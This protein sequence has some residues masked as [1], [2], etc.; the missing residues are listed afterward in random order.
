MV[1]FRSALEPRTVAERLALLPAA[2]RSRF[3]ARM[4]DDQLIDFLHD[5]RV[6]ARPEQLPPEGDW[7]IWGVMSGRGAGKTRLAGEWFREQIESGD[8]PHS[9][10]V[11]R[12]AGDVRKTMIEGPSGLL[13]ICHPDFYP[14]YEPSKKQIT[15]P[16]GSI[17]LLFN[18]TEP[19]EAR[20][21]QCSLF[22][23]DEVAAWKRASEMWDQ[24][25]MGFRLGAHPRGVFTTTPRPIKLMRELAE[26]M[27]VVWSPRMSTYDNA[28]NL[29][30]TFL[31]KILRKYEGTRQ[32]RQEL[33]GELLLDMPGALWRLAWLDSTRIT[34]P[35]K[36]PDI[37][38][39]SAIV[40]AIDP[41]VTS[42]EDSNETGIIAA[43]KD[44]RDPAH[45]YVLRDVSGRWTATQWAKKAVRL[46]HELGADRI[47]GEVNNGGDLIE[48][49][50]R[51][52]DPDIPYR[53]VRAT[54][55][56]YVRGEPVAALYEQKRVHHISIPNDRGLNPL[57]SLEDQMVTFLPDDEREEDSPDRADAAIWA[58]T[59]LST[60]YDDDLD[61]KKWKSYKR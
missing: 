50:L 14:E 60:T 17:T 42:G 55:G 15:W 40:I 52:V 39:M 31:T 34:D 36:V 9:H 32:G 21:P 54:R 7:N 33:L 20:G 35:G 27:S 45:Y 19:D 1:D 47:V 57:Q 49:Q 11:G 4:D 37:G 23:A 43:A 48:A 8:H 6:W 22:W 46:F 26:D 59:D 16:N 25:M 18:A 10:L 29:A 5:W 44:R 38:E 56:K 3:L 13:A 2:E 28:A 30:E 61:P 58:I 41:A 53:A 24:L 51:Q 12:S